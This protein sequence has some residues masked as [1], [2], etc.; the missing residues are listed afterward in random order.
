[1]GWYILAG[2][3]IGLVVIGS[4][5]AYGSM[6]WQGFTREVRGK[7]EEGREEIEP[8]VFEESELDGL[9]EP[10]QRYFRRVLKPGQAMIAAVRVEHAGTFNLSGEAEKWVPF[11]STQRVITRRRGFDWDARI[12][13]G[14]GLS[15]LVH[16]AYL[17]GEGILQASVMGLV[18]FMDLPSTPELAK[19]ELMRWFAE[20]AWYPTALLP[21]QGVVWEAVDS[22]S[23]KAT[24][25]EGDFTL[26]M[27]F[28]FRE[29]GLIESQ[30]VEARGRTVGKAVIPTPWEGRWSRYEERDGMLVP[31]EGEVSWMMEEGAKPYWRGKILKIAYEY[32]V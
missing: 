14:P 1:M 13:M 10:V 15:A 32:A 2:V 18:K 28:R 27:T 9:P 19:G 4:A 12:Q 25:M 24:L 21:S 6:R 7:L 8:K 22:T 31:L 29:D 3:V 17:F 5:A 20:A 26:A 16:D 23:A 30:R 11:R